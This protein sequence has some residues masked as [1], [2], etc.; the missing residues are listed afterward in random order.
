MISRMYPSPEEIEEKYLKNEHLDKPFILCE[1]AH[2]MG[3]SPEIY[4]HTRNWL[5]NMTALSVA[6]FGNGVIMRF[7]PVSKM[8]KGYL[9][10]GRLW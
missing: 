1:Y 4:M 2:A 8:A 9:D 10:M 6:L 3:N 7:R 5:N